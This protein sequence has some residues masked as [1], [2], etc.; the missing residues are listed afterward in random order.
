M[1]Y[2][3]AYSSESH[4]DLGS[5]GLQIL[6]SIN[7]ELT[8]DEINELY[9]HAE[10]IKELLYK[11]TALN[12][13]DKIKAGKEEKQKILALFPTVIHAREIPNGYCNHACCI[14]LPWLV[15]TTPVGPITIGWRKRVISISW[16]DSD[17]KKTAEEL[18]PDESTTKYDCLIHAW[19]YEK[20]AEY[21]T[22]LMVSK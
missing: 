8:D 1:D 13:P 20:A 3:K 6:V 2:I 15:V 22:K 14:H 17:V 19:G 18:F 7:R 16:E 5:L 11:N 9:K 21:V 12:D 10:K 4:G